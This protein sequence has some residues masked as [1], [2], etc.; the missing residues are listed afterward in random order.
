MEPWTLP[1]ACWLYCVGVACFGGCMSCWQVLLLDEATSA[2]D[3][4]SEVLVQE[5][6]D[7]RV[8]AVLP[9][10]YYVCSAYVRPLVVPASAI[11][12]RS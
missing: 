10:R 3:A 5:A 6:I 1:A 12:A 8:L 9:S 11:A 2:L 4:E 7:R